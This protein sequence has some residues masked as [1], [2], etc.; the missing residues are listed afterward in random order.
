MT[1]YEITVIGRVQGVGFRYFAL[2]RAQELGITGW[3]KNT[4]DGNVQ[5]IAQG[6]EPTLKTYV[7]FL[8]LGPTLSRVDKI[9]IHRSDITSV[10]DNFSVKY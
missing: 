7:D 3:A 5:I 8:R 10:F 9:S 6:D 4:V 1:Q 2:H